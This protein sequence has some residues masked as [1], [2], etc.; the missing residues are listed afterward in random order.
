MLCSMASSQVQIDFLR[1]AYLGKRIPVYVK[2]QQ[3]YTFDEMQLLLY[4]I[5]KTY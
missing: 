4:F 1:Q 2:W 5:S 3:I